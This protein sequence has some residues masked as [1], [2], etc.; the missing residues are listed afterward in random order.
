MQMSEIERRN[1]P[2]RE[3]CLPSSAPEGLKPCNCELGHYEGDHLVC[4]TC[5]KEGCIK[6]TD[7]SG[8]EATLRINSRK[9]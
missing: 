7:P 5:G 2:I 8:R 4:N 9:R 1:V 3:H 6:D